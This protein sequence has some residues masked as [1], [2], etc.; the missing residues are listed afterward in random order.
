MRRLRHRMP[1]SHSGGRHATVVVLYIINV[2]DG[3]GSLQHALS[4]L[5]AVTIPR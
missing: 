1:Y 2:F 5:Y 3:V 4:L